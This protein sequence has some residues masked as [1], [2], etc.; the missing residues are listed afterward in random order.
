MGEEFRYI[1]DGPTFEEKV[2][3]AEEIRGSL[4]P[5]VVRPSAYIEGPEYYSEI[6]LSSLAIVLP[7]GYPSD[8]FFEWK[9]THEFKH[10]SPDGSPHTFDDAK[11]VEA[12]ILA[13]Y[14]H[15]DVPESL[16][17]D[18][19]NAADDVICDLQVVRQKPHLR[20]ILNAEAE[21]TMRRIAERGET[22]TREMASGSYSPSS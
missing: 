19:V 6:H 10:M 13:L 15:V 21:E 20:K 1:P 16:L 2:A 17:R 11:R 3:K 4:W 5:P 22:S 18:A 9:A 12:H 8:D 7:G 14:G